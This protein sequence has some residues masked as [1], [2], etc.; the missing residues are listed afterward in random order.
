[1]SWADR[2]SA[3]LNQ[4]EE[5]KKKIAREREIN[6]RRA[7]LLSQTE[8]QPAPS[9]SNTYT[10]PSSPSSSN[11]MNDEMTP[12][13]ARQL[14]QDLRQE[15]ADLCNNQMQGQAA[16]VVPYRPRTR[17]E[18]IMENFISNPLQVHNQLNPRKPILVYEGT[19]FPAWEAALDRT[20]RH[21]LVRE[22]PFT[23]K[24]DNFDSL[25][26]DEAS[27][28]VCLIRN[29]V[30]DALGDILDAA[31]LAAPKAIFELLKSK[32]SRSDRRRKVELLNELVTLM[33]D[34]APAMEATLLVWAK[35]KSE[36]SQLKMTWDEALGIFLQ[37]YYKAP[38]GVDRMTFEFTISQQL[39]DKEAPPFNDVSTII[40]FAANKLRNKPGATLQIPSVP[41]PT[42]ADANAASTVH[43]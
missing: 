42:T 3:K 5:E 12:A 4:I 7:D 10:I 28:V 36:L 34:P 27:T 13:Q 38:V 1:M 22:L 2:R 16:P 9:T 32:C 37:S 39:N 19:N 26:V 35:L 17:Q 18:K 11:K 24:V 8:N 30:V 14:F 33:N 25:A 21:V 15:I 29:T 31:K 20:I 6:Q 40:Q 23:D 41:N 43:Q